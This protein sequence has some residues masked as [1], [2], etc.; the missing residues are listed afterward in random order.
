[1]F[2]LQSY[3]EKRK[4]IIGAAL[5]TKLPSEKTRPE[6][7]HKAMRYC[8]FSGGKRL[9]PILCLAAAEAVGG[10]AEA[11]LPSALA[12]EILHTYT[13]IHDDLP[14][15]DDDNMR[16]G[17]P[18]C[19]VEFDEATA[20]LT[21]DAL[22]TLAFEILAETTAPGPYP[23]N[24]FLKELS[25]SAGSRGIVGGQAEDIFFSKSKRDSATINYIHLHKTAFLFRASVRMGGIAG[26]ATKDQLASLTEYG[27][28]IGLAFQII[29]DILDHSNEEN[30]DKATCL[31]LY[32]LDS[33]RTNAHLSVN[34]AVSAL[35]KFESSRIK[36]M[37]SIARFV[38]ERKI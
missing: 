34:T 36:P 2:D 35:A 17:K 7:L 20:I 21:G 24:Q 12:V 9:R 33:A 37:H 13:L 31:A 16:R 15:M 28:N 14:C 22:Q 8:V 1:M 30:T 23:P 38:I 18:A 10:T 6:L 3:L 11:A 5:E 27:T 25:Y 26:G 32:D 19:H 29:D 4:K